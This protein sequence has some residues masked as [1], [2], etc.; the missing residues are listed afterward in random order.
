MKLQSKSKKM[1]KMSRAELRKKALGPSPLTFKKI[2][3]FFINKKTFSYPFVSLASGAIA[4]FVFGFSFWQ[5]AIFTF[6]QLY[7]LRYIDN[8][9]DQDYDIEHHKEMFYHKDNVAMAYVFDITFVVFNIICFQWKGLVSILFVLYMISFQFVWEYLE[10]LMSCLM[11]LYFVWLYG[12]TPDWKL[13]VVLIVC[14]VFS[15]IYAAYKK[16]LR[17]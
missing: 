5:F 14:F 16:R 3:K 15:N 10:T 2:C 11:V 7:S 13:G 9:L 17:K 8:C 4:Y 6:L 12:Y 1:T